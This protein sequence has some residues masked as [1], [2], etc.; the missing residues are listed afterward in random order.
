MSDKCGSTDTH[1]GEPCKNNASED[2]GYCHLHTQ[3][4][5]NQRGHKKLSHDRQEKIAIA[6]EQGVPLVAACRLNG[7]TH[8]THRIW[9]QKGEEQEEGPYAQYFQRLTDVLP[10]EYNHKEHMADVMSEY[11]GEDSWNWKG[12]NR[13]YRGPHWHTQRKMALERDGYSCQ[14]CGM[15]DK[16]HN[17]KYD[18]G[19]HVHHIISR[20]QFLEDDPDQNDLSNLVTL[21]HQCH[22]IYEGT[23][24][25]PVEGIT[26]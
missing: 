25:S 11:S 5:E 19:L 6:L 1:S 3:D 10:D 8:K 21:C 13:N 22:E 20:D 17:Q 24:L 12:G 16:E 9:M 23:N 26:T 4:D 14:S 15:H 2:D 18:Y 7:I